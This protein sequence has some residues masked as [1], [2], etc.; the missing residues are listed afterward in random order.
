MVI[1][2]QTGVGLKESK[3]GTRCATGMPIESLHAARLY[4]GSAFRTRDHFSF[5]L[6]VRP[7]LFLMKWKSNVG[8]CGS[9][10]RDLGRSRPRSGT[11]C[12]RLVVSRAEDRFK[13]V[14]GRG[15]TVLVDGK[16]RTS[17]HMWGEQGC[18]GYGRH[19]GRL[20][21]RFAETKSAPI[22]PLQDISWGPQAAGSIVGAWWMT[23]RRLHS[24]ERKRLVSHHVV[25]L[26]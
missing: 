14:G 1:Y 13:A 17:D 21:P 20:G 18:A 22:R 11:N 5:M 4:D 9:S 6:L 19:D 12:V 3:S 7:W 25:R 24:K 15:V 8:G 23:G 2:H 10:A 16:R 26:G